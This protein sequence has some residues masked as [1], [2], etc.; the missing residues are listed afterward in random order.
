MPV[1][2]FC[3]LYNAKFF[4]FVTRSCGHNS[5]NNSDILWNNL[6]VTYYFFW[7]YPKKEHLDEIDIKFDLAITVKHMV[8]MLTK[9]R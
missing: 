8:G 6:K 9:N 7:I 4:K 1:V 3:A 5:V 2:F